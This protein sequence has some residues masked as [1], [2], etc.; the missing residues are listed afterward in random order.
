MNDNTQAENQVEPQID[1]NTAA[2]AKADFSKAELSKPDLETSFSGRNV[3]PGDI[4]TGKI[5][6]ITGNVAF[7]DYGAR[8]E[9]YIELSELKDNDGNLTVNEGDE[10]ECAVVQT[11]GAIQLSRKKVQAGRVMQDLEQAWRDKT[12]VKGKIVDINKGGFEVRVDGVRA[13]CPASQFA[14]HF[15]RD[16]KNMVGKEFEFLITEF[17]KGKSL[18]ISRRALL[19][20]QRQELRESLENQIKVGE[21]YQGKVTQVKDFGA[22]VEIAPGV[23]GLVHVSEISHEHINK[24]SD[25]LNVGDAIEVKVIRIDT[26]KGRVAL[27]MKEL[28]DDPWTTYARSLQPGQELHGKVAR[29]QGFGAFVTLQD[30]IDGLLHISAITT[31]K[32][33]ENPSEVL[34]VGQEIDVVVERVDF[35]R[36]RIGLMTKEVAQSRKPKPVAAIPVKV[37]EVCTGKV[38]RV[39]SYGV[40]LEIAPG[41]V[42]LIPNAEMATERGADHAK[43]FPIGTELEVK[44]Q[45]IDNEKRRIRLSRKALKFHA[46]E[47]DYADYRAQQKSEAHSLGTFGDLLKDYLSKR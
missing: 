8:S 42:G 30:N 4:V 41:V 37:G 19:E 12:P 6:K 23:E 13:F 11:R 14:D 16:P 9:G 45:D 28:Q 25:K 15:V 26:D 24:P 43:L 39:E 17:A 31:G 5:V 47:N 40:F 20:A 44:V 27:S 38:T 35:E 33:I 29:I 36:R 10:I 32:R 7:V 18:V 1:N 2:N 34:S 3:N 46:E 21:V 22:F